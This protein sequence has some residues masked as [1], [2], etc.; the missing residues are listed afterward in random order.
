VRNGAVAPYDGD[1]ESYR[2]LLLDE[3]GGK[4]NKR[5]DRGGDT[6]GARGDQRRATAG[7]RAELA[8]LKKAL[9]AAEKRVEKLTKDVAALD[10]VLA[11]TKLYSADPL[12]AQ[13]AAQE[14]AQAKRE[15]EA[16]E[17]AW[18]KATEA[19]EEASAAAD[20]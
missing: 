8:P 18:L 3:R 20:A 19:Y 13:F 6:K 5:N 15:L 1:M 10:A 9:T 4:S 17:E 16:A 12:R 14:R 11:D 7:R 2:T